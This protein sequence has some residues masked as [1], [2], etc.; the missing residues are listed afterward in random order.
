MLPQLHLLTIFSLTTST[1][2]TT[3]TTTTMITTNQIVCNGKPDW[4]DDGYCDDENN[5]E[6]CGWDGGDCCGDNVNTQYCSVCECLD[7]TENGNSC[8]LFKKYYKWY[9]KS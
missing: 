5:N 3:T 2:T 8:Q 6:E 9:E 7:P 4:I 1:T